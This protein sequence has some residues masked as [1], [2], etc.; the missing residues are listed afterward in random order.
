[1][2]SILISKEGFIALTQYC[3]HSHV[4]C[5]LL[6]ILYMLRKSVAQCGV[7]LKVSTAATCP[8]LHGVATQS[9][10]SALL[11]SM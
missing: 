9:F 8:V 11:I 6:R 10:Q 3:I 7:L 2:P 5:I 1:M 4:S